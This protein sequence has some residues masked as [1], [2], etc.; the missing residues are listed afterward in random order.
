MLRPRCFAQDPTK[1]PILCFTQTF[2]CCSEA[3]TR[4]SGAWLCR[5]SLLT[6][7][8]AIGELRCPPTASFPPLP[9]HTRR[10]NAVREMWRR[11]Q[12]ATAA[13]GDGCPLGCPF[14]GSKR[15]RLSSPVS[16]DAVLC[17]L[18]R[19]QCSWCL[20]VDSH[21]RLMLVSRIML[22][23]RLVC[24]LVH[25]RSHTAGTHACALSYMHTRLHG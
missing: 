16:S 8:E 7:P 15:R 11:N 17:C 6:S 20:G 5:A 1:H 13:R 24:R 23:C 3:K 12:E 9:T 4:C 18:V 2:L 14:D 10:S 19:R 21:A 25:A 22:V